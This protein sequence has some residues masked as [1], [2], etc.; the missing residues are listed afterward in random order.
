VVEV[1]GELE[2]LELQIAGVQQECMK[3]NKKFAGIAFISFQ[4]EDMKN[5]VL[6]AN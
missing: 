3:S 6:Q 4:S 1:N 2:E 5:H